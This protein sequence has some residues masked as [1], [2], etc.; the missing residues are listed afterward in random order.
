MPE[1]NDSGRLDPEWLTLN[2]VRDLM[3]LAV[4]GDFSKSTY[5]QALEL[6]A[7]ICPKILGSD[8]SVL[9]K[10]RESELTKEYRQRATY[11]S[12]RDSMEI[13]ALS[14]VQDDINEF[15]SLVAAAKESKNKTKVDKL[16]RKL[17]KLYAAEEE[18]NPDKSSENQLIFRD[19]IKVDRGLPVLT[20]GKNCRTF[21]LFDQ[22]ILTIRVLH[23]EIPE[24]I[25]GADLIYE[26]YDKDTNTVIIALV[27]YKIWE[28]KKMYFSN[29][30]SNK[31]MLRQIDKMKTFL[32]DKGICRDKNENQYR[33]PCCSAFLRPTDKL[34][35]PNQA[36]ISTGEHLPIC[37]IEECITISP[38]GAK[39]LEYDNVRKIS[40]SHDMFEELFNQGKIGSKRLSLE[41]LANL[42]KGSDI[43]S[44]KDSMLLYAREYPK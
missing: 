3:R 16:Q 38:G 7:T 40:L 10:E 18:I 39:V 22:N 11:R 28:N 8:V 32:C 15:E 31:R 34:Q 13:T 26:K 1:N 4:R 42:Y 14:L 24:H 20:E 29:N 23:P 35:S 44:K 30:D 43:V 25:T 21:E 17:K 5:N 36:F 37:H 9:R 33:F 6:G 2:A 41:E 19:A 12:I 27:Q